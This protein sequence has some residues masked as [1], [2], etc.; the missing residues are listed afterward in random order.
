MT[1]VESSAAGSSAAASP[2]AGSPAL[3]D[4][5]PVEMEA[6][7]SAEAMDLSA[8]TEIEL[9]SPALRV[10]FNATILDSHGVAPETVIS[11]EDPFVVKWEICV[12]GPLW[13]L[14]C[15]CWCV[16][17]KIESLGGGFEGT[18][19]ELLGRGC[20]FR[21]CFDGCR[22][23]YFCYQQTVPAGKLEAGKCSSLYLM[24]ATFQLFDHCGKPAPIV[25]YETLGAYS[26]YD[27]N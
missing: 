10:W 7:L 8:A 25:G 22:Y 3:A 12:D 11:N 6:S 27:P 4:G 23:R 21:Y 5:I 13:R 15:G 24:S 18:L 26:F 20:G 16:D 1:N 9:P 2:A 19:S 17:L 14:I